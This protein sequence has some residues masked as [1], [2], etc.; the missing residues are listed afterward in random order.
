[1]VFL[2][3]LSMLA[4]DNRVYHR[5]D[6]VLEVTR[7]ARHT[8]ETVEHDLLMT[9]FL[10]DKQTIADVG[11]DGTASTGDDLIGQSAIVY[12]APYELVV[13][14][15]VSP[16]I[17][18]IIDGN[19]GD[20]LPTGYA[21]V[22]FHTG[23]ETLRY[24]L[25]SNGDGTI[26]TADK[27][28]EAEESIIDN[29][30]LYLLRR[31]VYGDNG[32]DNRS[33]SGPVGLVRGPEAYPSG[34]KPMPLFQYWGNFYNRTGLTLWGDTGAG[35]GV[36]YN[37]ILE[38]GEL[39][40]LTAVTAED[41][42]GNA[43]L[44]SG[45][46]RNGNGTLDRRVGDIVKKVDI[47]VTVETPYPD[48][49]YADKTRSSTTTPFRY[50][51]VT[52]STQIKP[53][54]ID[55]PGGACGD[56]P[57]PTASI[58]VENACAD[59]LSDG[60]VR[61][62]WALSS[63][64]G[65][66]E[67]DVEKY[68]MYR[69]DVDSVFGTTPYSEANKGETSYEDDWV[70][71][72]TWPPRQYWYRLRA[73]DCT[74]QLSVLDPIGGAY[75]AR[76]GAQYPEQIEI[77][78]IPGDDGTQLEVVFG[79]SADE[80]TNTTGYGA[81]VRKYYVHRSA[82]LDYRCVPPVNNTAIDA[83][84]AAQYT[85][86]DNATNSTSGLTWGTLYYYWMRAQDSA[87]ALS[88]YSPRYCGRSY[89]GPVFPVAQHARVPHYAADD[90]PV[91]IYFTQDERN[92][93][94]GYDPYLIDYNIYRAFDYNGDG[95]IN[96]LVDHSAGYRLSDRVA[97]IRWTGLVYAAGGTGSGKVHQSLDGGAN[98]REIGSSGGFRPNGIA[99]GNR[100]NAVVVGDNGDAFYSTT[101]GATWNASG[102]T[103]AVDLNAV[104][105]LS[106]QTVMAIGNNGTVLKSSDGGATFSALTVSLT[107]DLLG[108]AVD[109]NF[110]VVVGD[111]GAAAR[112]V[113]GGVNWTILGFAG[114]NNL[115][116][117]TVAREGSGD[118]TILAGT[119]DRI[120]RSSDSGINW[121]ALDFAGVGR[122]SAIAAVPG[123]PAMAVVSTADL[124]YRSSDGVTWAPEGPAPNGPLAVAMLNA[125]IAWVSDSSGN[126][127]H[128]D[129]A[130]AWSNA[131]LGGEPLRALAVR[132]E[133][134]WEDTTTSSAASGMPFFYVVTA[135]YA[136]TS[137]LDGESGMITDRAGTLEVPDDGEDQILV[138]SCNNIELGATIP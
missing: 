62:T 44:D 75:P 37:G 88:P 5:D 114:G 58:T 70:I 92:E 119:D 83:T 98:W 23:A 77:R 74:P 29:S 129:H 126:V 36:A 63:D 27:R 97:T 50:R 90:H 111:N 66:G 61:I 102:G 24:T 51:A 87:S 109:G 89:K 32:T 115:Y 15:D 45:E 47:H 21:P 10:V 64:D 127:F 18:A 105:F 93:D 110:V 134:A 94:A 2:A 104:A 14:A 38:P 117:V 71:M 39:A 13:N 99:F 78:D 69:T 112:S 132:P 133:L 136:Q 65:A 31:E 121:T 106:E 35:G 52:M 46:D 125:N 79:R 59:A 43:V 34:A 131:N 107:E 48:M 67:M 11:P 7:E 26:N 108:I 91:E 73:M 96:S 49:K 81:V 86:V 40:A 17:E 135:K 95:T 28:D 55:L 101:G 137:A 130:G 103:G 19:T 118:R 9:G 3:A 68:I 4:I 116:G 25:D 8:L 138:D 122:F 84:N 6:A 120:W 100:L 41:A 82:S 54:N 60:K 22:T 33:G 30:G 53:R 124:I 123:G 113:D 16:E 56:Q 80:M 128:R 42:N 85:F 20:A 12:A 57:H 76:V 72:R 1:M